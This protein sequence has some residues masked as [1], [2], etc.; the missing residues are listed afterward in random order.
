MQA[1]LVSHVRALPPS[2]RACTAAVLLVF[3]LSCLLT[4]T[5][6]CA[7]TQTGL[8]RE[9]ALYQV[10]TNVVGSLQSIVPYVPAPAGPAA[11]IAL[12]VVSTLLASWNLHQ[13]QQLKKLKNGNGNGNGNGNKS[14]AGLA[15]SAKTPGTPQQAP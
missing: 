13:Q 3:G 2:L 11:E 9:Q 12:A 8:A 6:S 7:H 15:L 1:E 10:G 5:V 14:L 4:A